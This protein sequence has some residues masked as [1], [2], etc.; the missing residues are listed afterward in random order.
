MRESF[1]KRNKYAIIEINMNNMSM[2]LLYVALAYHG[3]FLF[4][5]LQFE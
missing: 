1:N 4:Y 3:V 5:Q 2:I